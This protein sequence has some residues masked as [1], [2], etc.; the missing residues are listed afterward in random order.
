[1]KFY[2][3]VLSF[4]LL[5]PSV[6]LSQ[7]ASEPMVNK[8]VTSI[9]STH[10]DRP[11]QY[12]FPYSR[13]E[14][15]SDYKDKFDAYGIDSGMV[16]AAVGAASGW[17]EGIFSVFSDD[18]TY[19]VQ[20]IKEQIL[21]Q[22]Q[23]DAVVDHFSRQRIT[24]QTNTFE[25][26]IGSETETKLPDGTF[27]LLIINNTFHEFSE[28]ELMIKDIASKI[29]DDGRIVIC[30][31]FSNDEWVIKHAGCRIKGYKVSEIKEMFESHGLYLTNTR[32]PEIAT[33]NYL[34]FEKNKAKSD[35][36]EQKQEELTTAL[37]ALESLLSKKVLKDW[38]ALLQVED[39]LVEELPKLYQVYPHIQEFFLELSDHYLDKGKYN[40]ALEVLNMLDVL[41]PNDPDSPSLRGDVLYEASLFEEANEYYEIAIAL[42]PD[43]IYNYSSLI[44]SCADSWDWEI[45]MK[46]YLQGLEVDSTDDYLHG[47]LG[48]LFVSMHE[49]E[50]YD[51]PY[52]VKS[53]EIKVSFAAEM[54]EEDVLEFALN[55]FERAITLA[56]LDPDYNFQR[57]EVYK[58]LGEYEKAIEDY[59]RV[60]YLDPYRL[61]IYKFRAKAKR[62]MGDEAGYEADL[63]ELKQAR[64][65]LKN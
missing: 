62:A 30:E 10:R 42:D 17:M 33:H 21:N 56:P 18:V 61:Y 13:D 34:T 49:N 58:Q 25:W 16:V 27:D 40:R 39:V 1:M 3:F 43:E 22:E 31:H 65:D 28:P 64:K 36:Y 29:K 2:S 12:G 59:D 63:E 41:M 15:L 9:F 47:T 5:L 48:E 37:T 35:K 51:F 11:F 38:E 6:V 7:E 4:I 54:E 44:L 55:A 20:D 14:I 23:L 24:P 57:A 45:G 50:Y 52:T 53:D 26:V 60:L 8:D 32:L 19:Y 46:T